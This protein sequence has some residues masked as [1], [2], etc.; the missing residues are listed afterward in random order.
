M[1]RKRLGRDCVRMAGGG[2][3]M[4]AKSNVF[5]RWAVSGMKQ[6]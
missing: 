4:E 3:G 6:G 5:S 2:E 1:G